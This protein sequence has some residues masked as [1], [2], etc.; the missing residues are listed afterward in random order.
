MNK[1]PLDIRY[2]TID[3]ASLIHAF[4]KKL[5]I[6]EKLE[7]QMTATIEDIRTSIFIDHRAE[8]LIAELQGQPI[9]FALYFY[10][11]STFLGKANLFLEDL[12]IDVE[13]RHHGYGKQLFQ[14]VA[15]I[16]V[17]RGCERL[18]WMC[19][20]WNAPSIDF[21]RGLGAIQMNEWHV[22]R[23]KGKALNQVASKT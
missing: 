7:D 6:Y 11:Y 9:G 16:A 5:A 19:L 13:H 20:D 10:N 23:L 21:Y 3:D 4:I 22:F 14:K 8:V 12:F 17:N 15:E 2:A 1:Q 18:D